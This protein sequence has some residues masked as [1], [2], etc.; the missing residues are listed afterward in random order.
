MEEMSLPSN[1][2]AADSE[3]IVSP[4][5]KMGKPPKSGEKASEE[6]IKS[7]KENGFSR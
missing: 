5:I 3:T 4:Q 2:E 1:H 7:W 6:A